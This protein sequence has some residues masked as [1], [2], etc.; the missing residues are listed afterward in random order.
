LRIDY[1]LHSKHKLPHYQP[2]DS[3]FFITF[4]LAFNLPQTYISK[5]NLYKAELEKQEAEHPNNPSI[6]HDNQKRLFGLYDTLLDSAPAEIN[7]TSYPAIAKII[8]DKL[9]SLHNQQYYLYVFTVMPNHVHLVIKPLMEMDAPIPLSKIMQT[10]KGST[11]FEINKLLNRNGSL[12]MREYFDYCLR[13]EEE[14]IKI[15]DYIRN[16]PVKAKL[17][18][19]C[20]TWQWTW[21]NPDLLS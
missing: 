12:W 4:R 19:H 18:V 8:F 17:D 3:V 2:K 15:I 9:V 7:L 16:N 6:K 10:I 1:K 13:S 20:D 5:Y 11:S 14:L 21:L